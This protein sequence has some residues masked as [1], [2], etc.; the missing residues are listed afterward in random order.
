[1]NFNSQG[2]TTENTEGT[3]EIKLREGIALL[4]VLRVLRGE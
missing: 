3:E 4:R 2:L 1:M